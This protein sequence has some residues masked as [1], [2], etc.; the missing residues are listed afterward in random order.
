MI[1]SF[2]TVFSK[3][4]FICYKVEA[5]YLFYQHKGKENFLLQIFHV[6]AT[7]FWLL[8]KSLIANQLQ[9]RYAKNPNMKLFHTTES[10]CT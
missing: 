4:S 6:I 3:L 8:E 5:Q 7:S 1:Y 2:V 9:T 10:H